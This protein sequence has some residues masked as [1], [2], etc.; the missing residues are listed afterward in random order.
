MKKK[1]N[2]FKNFSIWRISFILFLFSLLAVI[3]IYKLYILQVQRGDFYRALARGQ[4]SGFQIL[5]G[6]RG[7]IYFRG[8]EIL[9]TNIKTDYVFISPQK[10]ENKEETAEKL[11]EILNLNKDEILNKLNKESFFEKIKSGLTR[12]EKEAIQKEKLRGVYLDEETIRR[13]PQKEMASHLVGFLSKDGKGHY[14]IE[15]YYN[16]ILSG[17]EKIFQNKLFFQE[18]SKGGEIYLTVD[19]NIQFKAEELLKE[20]KENFD[21]E[22]G[23]IIVANPETG[24]ILAMAEFPNFDPNNY[25]SVEDFSIFKNSAVQKLFEPGS[26]F[27]PITMAAALDQNKITPQ[28]KYFDEGVVKIGGRS[29]HNYENRSFGEQTMTNVLEKSI[30]TGAVFA[31]RQIGDDVF[32]SYIEKF[33]FFKPTGI[34]IQG[35]I[36]S[37]NNEL[38]KGYKINFATASFGQGIEVTPVQIVKAF[39]AVA[40]GG[41]LV[42]PYLASKIVKDGKE[43]IIQPQKTEQILKKD[44]CQKLTEMMISVIDNGPYAKRARVPGYY[45]AGKTG[46]SQISWAAYGI[47]KKGYSD[48]TWQSFIGFAPA[49]SPKFL[50][51]VK[52][53]NPKTKSSEYSA[54][55]VFGE[56]AKY[57][58]NY[59]QIPPTK[60]E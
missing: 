51:L 33:G 39:S 60:E 35:E 7:N 27:K 59:Y 48:K 28:T 57:L 3:I 26:I 2:N 37:E 47:N 13:Y 43:K 58:L 41:S 23:Q 1:Y 42:K 31:E 12:E 36:F 45:I 52:L 16:D 32:L 30:N 25:S 24:E 54:T 50:V 4:Q 20:A 19:Y 38:K 11:S 15:G 29:I 5:K 8:G 34:D 17:E 6:E 55:P 21:I 40:N 46:T 56:M 18:E 14:G 53:D 22:G 44:T 49:F 10:I 9:A